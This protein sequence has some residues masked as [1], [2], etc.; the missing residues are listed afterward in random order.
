MP[1]CCSAADLDLYAAGGLAP[2]DEARVELHLEECTACAMRAAG[3]CDAD[4]FSLALREADAAYGS[5]SEIVRETE[6]TERAV[7][8]RLSSAPLRPTVTRNRPT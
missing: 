2:P 5:L 7:A 6:T 4:G 1:R 3:L 8:S